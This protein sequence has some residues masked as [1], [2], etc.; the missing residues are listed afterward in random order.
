MMTRSTARA[1][2]FCLTPA[3]LETAWHAARACNGHVHAPRSLAVDTAAQPFDVFTDVLRASFLQRVPIVGVCS[4]GILIRI[5]APLLTTKASDPPVVCVAETGASV[6]PLI[7]GHAGA[8]NLAHSLATQ[9]GA[10][11]A[12]TTASDLALGVALDQPPAGWKLAQPAPI[13][14]L[15]MA[16]MADRPVTISSSAAWLAPL[17]ERTNVTIAAAASAPEPLIIASGTNHLIY[18]KQDLA[19]GVGCSRNCPSDELAGLVGKTLADAGIALESLSGVFSAHIKA[20]EEAVS[21]LGQ[22]LDVPVRYYSIAELN[23]VTSCLKNPSEEVFA[24]IG[25]HGVAEAAALLAAGP[26]GELLVEKQKSANATCAIARKGKAPGREGRARGLLSLV[27]IGPGHAAGQTLE[28][29]TAILAADH[30]VG[31][32]GYL[33]LVMPMLGHQAVRRFPLG[34]ELDRC[35]Y[36]LEKAA[37][38]AKVVLICSGDSGIYAMAA[39]VMEMLECEADTLPP[40][41]QRIAIRCLPGVSAMQAASARSGAILGHDFAAVSLSDLMTPTALVLD[42]VRT[43]AEGDF[44]I[45]LYN[46]ASRG[47]KTLIH[48]AIETIRAHRSPATPVLVA[49]NVGRTDETCTVVTL[50][51]VTTTTID[52]MTTLIIGNSQTRT[53]DRGNGQQIV[54]TPRG[55]TDRK[56]M[57][58]S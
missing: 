50:E 44:V 29:T 52:M 19:L 18:R 16:I 34:E 46:P 31:Y 15:T 49:R 37:S 56:A 54:Y 41:T 21:D 22:S 8:N 45:A 35:R 12:I 43:A 2:I 42:R 14:S 6:I 7:G 25:A 23:T 3:G 24:A 55:Y 28:A 20:D 10:H 4:A 32:G 40:E 39:P 58:D 11:A 9:L 48:H 5:L 36:A 13:K 47:R 38:G 53:F 26:D 27:G 30:V 51:T 17:L 57:A 33:D 1:H